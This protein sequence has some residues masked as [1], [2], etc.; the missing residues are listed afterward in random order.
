[1]SE[2]IV[3]FMLLFAMLSYNI[4]KAI[5]FAVFIQAYYLIAI[6]YYMYES[7]ESE[8]VLW[9]RF[10]LIATLT[11]FGCLSIQIISSWIGFKYLDL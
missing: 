3:Y 8:E 4:W 6:Q 10:F 11:T 1:M 9:L 5:I 7:K 2:T